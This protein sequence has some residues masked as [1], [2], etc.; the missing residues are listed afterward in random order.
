MVYQPWLFAVAKGMNVALVMAMPQCHGRW[1]IA[2]AHVSFQFYFHGAGHGCG[3][4]FGYGHCFCD[5]VLA[6]A[7]AMAMAV[8]MISPFMNFMRSILWALA[9]PSASLDR[10]SEIR[11]RRLTCSSEFSYIIGVHAC[12]V[13]LFKLLLILA[14]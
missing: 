6:M 11:R 8:S 9:M 7:L 5:T 14:S 1:A 3:S 4:T 12:N 10:H 13:E 2:L